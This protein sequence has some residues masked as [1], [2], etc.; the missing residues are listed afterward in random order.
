M[1]ETDRRTFMQQAAGVAAFAIQPA[2]F[3]A[4]L[5]KGAELTVALI[6]AG[7]QGRG[8]LG[9]L[10]KIEGVKV[11]AVCEI[12]ASRLRSGL[13][14]AQGAKGYS[15]HRKMFADEKLDAVFTEVAGSQDKWERRKAELVAGRRWVELLY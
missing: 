6:G 8:I 11:A 7:R 5:R 4:P 2:L 14:R 12:V 1:T 10:Q 13:R 9:E 3:A 15:D